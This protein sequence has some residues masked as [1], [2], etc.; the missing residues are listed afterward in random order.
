[1]IFELAIIVLAVCC[2][3]VGVVL[4]IRQN[5]RQEKSGSPI[6]VVKEQKVVAKKKVA[7]KKKPK[8]GYELL[9]AILK[10]KQWNRTSTN[11]KEN[12]V[13][14]WGELGTGKTTLA[15]PEAADYKEQS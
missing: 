6:K 3:A 11:D 5:T 9:K 14:V 8:D 10:L 1:L 13:A 7:K 2:V 4:I 12:I 15:L